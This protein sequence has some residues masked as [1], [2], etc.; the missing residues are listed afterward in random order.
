MKKFNILGML[1]LMLAVFTGCKQE[2]IV[3]TSEL[4][5]FQTRDGYML[6]EA[7]VPYGTGINDQIYIYGDFNGGED[8]IGDP[9]WLL[10]RGNPASGVPAKFGIYLNP[11][12]FQNGKTLADGYTFYN[13]QSGPERSIDNEP[14]LHHE[15][16]ALGQRQNV[17]VNYWESDFSTPENPDD[18]VHDGYAIY[19]LN[20]SSWTDLYLWAWDD[21]GNIAGDDASWPGLP[22]TGTM[23]IGGTMYTY[24]DT[25]ASNEGRTINIIISN[26]GSP[27]TP[28]PDPVITLNKDWYFE[29]TSD[30]TL[31]ELDPNASIEHD[32]YTVY[33]YNNTGWENVTLYMWG[34]VNDLNGAWPGMQ[35]TGTQ[36]VN[37]VGYLYFD[38]GE[39]NTGLAENLIFSNDGASQLGD[40]AFTI[41]RDIYLEITTSKVTEID[42][43][44]FHPGGDEPDEP[45]T[46]NP[47]P[48]NEYN[49]YILNNTGWSEFYVYAWGASEIFGG[50]PGSTTSETRVIDGGTYLVFTMQGG[51]EEENLIFNNNAGDQYDATVI[52]VDR[53]Y[54]IVAGPDNASLMDAPQYKLYVENL[55]GWDGVAV[56]A[57]GDSG[58]IFGGWP[59][60]VS[61]GTESVNGVSYEVFSFEGT[62]Q[63]ENFIFNNNGGGTQLPDFPVVLNQDYYLTVTAEGVKFKE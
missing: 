31:V 37:G 51:G 9:R 61:E 33:V 45:D 62:G 24:F 34:D 47:G 53:D 57:W 54:Y 5:Q 49:L 23:N 43:S 4:P 16:P 18:V 13:I 6:L 48:V 46:P 11:S 55:T 40:F 21:N 19:I 8:A 3:L 1:L 12:D 50:W 36:V 7:I 44:D 28:S 39:A 29:L 60:K 2:D 42:P 26:N 63:S 27:Q 17:F 59:G 38:M 58:E 52:A 25:G 35:P 30:G 20:N 22:A 14:I 41:N 10:E 15:Y 32:G 56:Y